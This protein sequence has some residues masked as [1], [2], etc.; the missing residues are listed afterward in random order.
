MSARAPCAIVL[1]AT[2]LAAAD[3]S[4]SPSKDVCVAAYVDAQH[5]RR[6][7][8]LRKAR[9]KL[10][11][12]AQPECPPML[13]NDCSPWLAEVDKL[14]PSV[15][16]VVHDASGGDLVDVT[17]ALDGA[18][19]V[20]R[21]VGRAVDVDPGDHVFRFEAA[22]MQPVELR[23]L[24][25]EGEKAR[26]LDVTLGAAAAGPPPPPTPR[27]SSSTAHTRRPLTPTCWVAL[28]VGAAG[29]TTSAVVGAANL[30]TWLR[31]RDG[32]CSTL[33]KQHSDLLNTVGDVAFV[34]GVAGALAAWY[35]FHNRPTITLEPAA[36]GATVQVR[37]A[38]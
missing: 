37:T 32:G 31:C 24:V 33:D 13:Q 17:V 7:G 20:A 29:I 36:S 26:R 3:P 18:P 9:E 35:F 15:V 5:A 38:F 16:F 2:S 8:A 1:A 23:V 12:C 22:G 34:T 21:L 11:M 30:P 10:V 4:P 6:D 14:I 25:R 28:A 27:P 19:L